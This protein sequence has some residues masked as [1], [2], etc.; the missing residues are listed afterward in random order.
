MMRT[1]KFMF[2]ASLLLATSAALGQ[3]SQGVIS[4]TVVNASD[5]R[6][7][8][9]Q[10][11]VVLRLQGE[12]QF[13]PFR[14]TQSDSQGRFRFDRLPVGDG[15]WYQA[16]GN[17]HGIHYPGPRVQ[18]TAAEPSA[19]VELKVHD[20]VARPNPLVIRKCE[21]TLKPELGALRVTERLLIDNPS[22]TSYVGEAAADGDEPV[23]LQLAIPPDFERTTFE[24]EFYG[25]RFAVKDG[26]LATGIPWP[27]GQRELKYTYVLR[28][29]ERHRLWQ[30]PLDLPCDDICIRVRTDKSDEVT[31][32]LP[33]AA[34]KNGEAVFQSSGDALPAGQVLCVTLGQLPV[35]W[36][37]Y[38]R[39]SAVGILL[40]AV[41]GA[42]FAVSRRT[43]STGFQPVVHG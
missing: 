43:R 8:P 21:I 12:G 6:M 40:A 14:E 24:E 25:R 36:T 31:C 34:G 4:G 10:A 1:F 22:T 7:S 23:T 17:R 30:R 27:P 29:A 15:Y 16:G 39:W 37:T 33:Q 5:G 9:C 32:D 41:G 20:A 19:S 38:A 18:L 3:S 35:P 13:V 2:A 28:N 42:G 26:K 11:D